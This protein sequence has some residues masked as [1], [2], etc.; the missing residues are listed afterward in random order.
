[1]GGKAGVGAGDANASTPNS[2]MLGGRRF[3]VEGFTFD[4]LRIIS[5]NFALVGE[6]VT[7][8]SIDAQRELIRA[9]LSDQISFEELSA[10]KVT[11]GELDGAIGVIAEASGLNALGEK[12]AR[13][14]KGPSTG[15]TSTL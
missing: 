2:F 9:A 6:A 13:A 11:L 5:P 1:M 3:R 14:T 15:T 10:L 8:A 12:I 7:A 4:Q